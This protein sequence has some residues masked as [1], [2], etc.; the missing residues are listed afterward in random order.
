MADPPD[1]RPFPFKEDRAEI[2][3]NMAVFATAAGFRVIA[4]VFEATGFKDQAMDLRRCA[5]ILEPTAGTA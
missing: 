3:P 4:D 1:V 2:D 5:V